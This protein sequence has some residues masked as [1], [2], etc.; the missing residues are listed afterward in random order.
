MAT[1]RIATLATSQKG[2]VCMPY[3]THRTQS[4]HLLIKNFFTKIS[5]F[6]SE[7]I[8]T[9]IQ[10]A[11]KAIGDVSVPATHFHSNI[12]IQENSQRFYLIFNLITGKWLVNV[13]VCG[14][15]K[16]YF[17]QI[18][19]IFLC[20]IIYKILSSCAEAWVVVIPARFV[21]HVIHQFYIYY[22]W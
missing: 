5:I 12:R 11:H 16:T 15:Q 17:V 14:K 9:F 22:V 20:C 19:W 3:A 18:V 2:R 10:T 4:S 13:V 1:T 8:Y 6:Y 7:C 21:V